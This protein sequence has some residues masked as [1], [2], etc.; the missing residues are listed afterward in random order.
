MLSER[1]CIIAGWQG[2][3]E[4]RFPRLAASTVASGERECR[5]CACCPSLAR[6]GE[7]SSGWRYGSMLSYVTHPSLQDTSLGGRHARADVCIAHAR[8]NSRHRG[9]GGGHH[10]Y[11][12]GLYHLCESCHPE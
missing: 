6:D 10:F 5:Y 7:M 2:K 12:D 9:L 3:V 8:C 4:V 1:M 11:G